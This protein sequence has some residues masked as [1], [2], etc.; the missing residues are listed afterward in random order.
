M[1]QHSTPHRRPATLLATLALL[2]G[3]MTTGCGKSSDLE[4]VVVAGRV[5]LDGQPISNGEIRFI[6]D[7]GTKG[8]IS[9]GPIKDGAYKADGRGGVP[10]GAH[11]VEIR[12]YRPQGGQQPAASEGGPAEQYVPGKYNDQTELKATIDSDTTTQDFELSSK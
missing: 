10:V 12:G 3:A 5:T 11:R 4:K 1:R 8:P 7:Q 9:G 6:P 2:I